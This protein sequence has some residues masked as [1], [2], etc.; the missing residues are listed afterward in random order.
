[1]IQSKTKISLA[2]S[3]AELT[4][5]KSGIEQIEIEQKFLANQPNLS[6]RDMQDI[7]DFSQNFRSNNQPY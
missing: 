1:M 6:A 4:K 2:K 7:L 5:G 3:L